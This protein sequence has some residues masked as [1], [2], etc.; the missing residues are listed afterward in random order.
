MMDDHRLGNA[1][2]L[3]VLFPEPHAPV[4]IHPVAL[5]SLVPLADGRQYAPAEQHASRRDEL[6][7]VRDHFI[8][9]LTVQ[10]FFY[11]PVVGKNPGHETPAPEDAV[12][13]GR[14]VPCSLLE[15]SVWIQDAR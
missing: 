1:E 13:D 9:V 14:E 10:V 5:I 8:Q 15:A 12:D 4:G 2:Y 11:E 6:H 7:P 3:F